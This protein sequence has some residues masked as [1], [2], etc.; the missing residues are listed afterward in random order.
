MTA[1]NVVPALQSTDVDVLVVLARRG[2][3]VYRWITD[4]T[5]WAALTA[6]VLDDRRAPITRNGHI[7]LVTTAGTSGSSEPVWPTATSGTV[8]DGTVVWTEAGGSW[9]PTYD[10]NAAAAEGWRWKAAL[11]AGLFD[12]KTDQQDFSR[13]QMSD[14]CLAMAAMY[15]KRV[16]G[17]I[18]QRG[19][20][21]I[22]PPPI[23]PVPIDDSFPV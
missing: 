21:P 8:T 2:D 17:S 6:Y 18:R 12:F 14:M 7:Y 11:V 23:I 15:A 4:D 16:T 19:S 3:D 5:E 9:A 22:I 10:L 13:S 20:L 1:W